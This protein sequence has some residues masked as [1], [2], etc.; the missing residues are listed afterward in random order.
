MTVETLQSSD[1]LLS[2]QQRTCSGYE[3]TV[4][5]SSTPKCEEDEEVA[6]EGPYDRLL[7][8]TEHNWCRAVSVG[9][10]ITV[11]GFLFRRSLNVSDL[12]TAVDV[13]QVSSHSHVVPFKTW[14][15]KHV[16]L[17]CKFV[18]CFSYLCICFAAKSLLIW[19]RDPFTH[20][21]CLK[22]IALR[23]NR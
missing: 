2:E 7:G 19:G 10:G 6:L 12:Q 20:R 4:N 8:D 18:I 16:C 3:P 1:A 22:E 21:Y 11:L 15:R 17:V 14:I 23:V 13:V 5:G 9:T